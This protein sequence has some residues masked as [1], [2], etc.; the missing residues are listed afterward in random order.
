LVILIAAWNVINVAV[1]KISITLSFLYSLNIRPESKKDTVSALSG[2]ETSVITCEPLMYKVPRAEINDVRTIS[3]A[4]DTYTTPG[5]H[6]RFTKRF[7]IMAGI[8]L[9]RRYG[10]SLDGKQKTGQ[11]V[12]FFTGA[13]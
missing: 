6:L 2:G 8:S 4:E 5:S 13:R 1:I 7:G 3:L 12:K 9:L 11:L 10:E